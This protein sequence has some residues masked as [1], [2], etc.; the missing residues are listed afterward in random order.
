MAAAQIDAESSAV[1]ENSVLKGLRILRYI[2][3]VDYLQ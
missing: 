2:L 1:H 3:A